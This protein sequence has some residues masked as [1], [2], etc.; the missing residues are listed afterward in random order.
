MRRLM[1]RM[2]AYFT[3]IEL[4][5]V[6]AIIA[7]LAAMILPALKSSMEVSR[8][9]KCANNIKQLGNLS[10][11]YAQDY[12]Y[13]PYQNIAYRNAKG[14]TDAYWQQYM[15]RDYLKIFDIKANICPTTGPQIVQYK[16]SINQ[17]WV[18][19]TYG[20]N[21]HALGNP[22][23]TYYKLTPYRKYHQLKFTARA[24]MYV[25][26]Y[27]HG[28]WSTGQGLGSIYE[29]INLTAF[30]HNKKANVT[31]MDGHAEL[32]KYGG[33]PAWECFS[34]ASDVQRYN[35]YFC[36]ADKPDSNFGTVG[37]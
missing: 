19:T 17:G 12:E 10:V 37:L 26:D 11:L 34:G 25:E 36:R 8:A 1:K 9:S 6:I 23:T 18:G 13:L 24:A 35:T 2:I 5:V 4:L 31:F 16:K 21:A 32:R 20:V 7:I 14:E 33:I 3:L 22:S 29:N 15:V 27:G 30:V 28:T